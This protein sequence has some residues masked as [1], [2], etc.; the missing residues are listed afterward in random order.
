MNNKVN[1]RM[2]ELQLNRPNENTFVG[3]ALSLSFY[4]IRRS[5]S[6]FGTY[7]T[8]LTVFVSGYNGWSL[9]ILWILMHTNASPF[10]CRFVS[11]VCFLSLS[12]AQCDTCHLDCAVRSLLILSL[13][14]LFP[15]QSIVCVCVR[16]YFIFI[17]C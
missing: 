12:F 5:R 8:R 14:M 10:M 4:S 7:E 17:I 11:C 1:R 9:L 2:P 15:W 6:Q 16:M 13:Y 3:C